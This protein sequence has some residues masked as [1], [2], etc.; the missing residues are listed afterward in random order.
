MELQS[1]IRLKRLSMQ[2]HHNYLRTK[3]DVWAKGW[4]NLDSPNCSVYYY[5][6]C[7]Y[8][9]VSFPIILFFNLFL[10]CT[11]QFLSQCAR[12]S[13]THDLSGPHLLLL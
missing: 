13:K 8:F 7:I 1:Q 10:N 11:V 3:K 2:V 4:E 12:L 5:Y 9:V 6:L